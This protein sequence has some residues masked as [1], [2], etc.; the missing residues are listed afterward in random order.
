MNIPWLRR[1]RHLFRRKAIVLMYHRIATVDIDPWELAVSPEN[2]EE[3]L[4]V[5]KQLYKPV[6]VSELVTQLYSGSILPKSVCLT[7]DD[8]YRDNYLIAKPLLE[9]YKCPAVFYIPTQYIGQEKKFWWDELQEIIL[10]SRNLPQ[11]L[12]VLINKER[13]NYA[14]DDEAELT[15]GQL[16]K[17]KIWVWPDKAPTRRCG[18]Y[19][20]LWEKLK[21]LPYQPIQEVLNQVKIWAGYKQ[22]PGIE[23]F[24]MTGEQLS[25]LAD[26]PLI[27]TGI[28]T[29]SHPAL[30]FHPKT[31]QQDEIAGN[32]R[33]LENYP[34]KPSDTIAYPYGDYN[35]VTISVVQEQQL[36]AAFTTE[37]KSVTR[38]ANPFRLGRFQVKN[39]NGPEFTT[40]LSKW[41]QEF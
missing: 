10:T 1:I 39:W 37:A 8:G 11:N 30:S 40:H 27:K 12:S 33:Y 35:D 5:L 31:V 2:F 22:A 9:R 13:F 34:G 21:P 14:I 6:P 15:P 24:P 18:L 26:H 41:V 36:K 28:H 38:E 23:A 4:K 7:F 17:H 25:D 19:L 3:Q 20:A 16:N 29:I 32:R